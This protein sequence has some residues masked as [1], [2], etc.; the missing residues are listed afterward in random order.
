M[1]HFKTLFFTIRVVWDINKKLLLVVVLFS[2]I[3]GISPI[4]LLRFT[5]SIINAI[6]S[7]TLPLEEVIFLII[8]YGIFSICMMLIQNTNAYFAT[9]LNIVLTHKVKYE[10]MKKCAELTLE[11]LEATETYDMITRL[12]S[13]VS[14]KPYQSLTALIQIVSASITFAYAIYSI[15]VW[16]IGITILL[17]AISTLYVIGQIKVAEKDFRMRFNRSDKERKLWYY[18]FLLT[19]D[20][21]FKEIKILNLKSYFLDRY[22]KLVQT[23][24]KEENSINRIG[25]ALSIV[26]SLAQD[27]MAMVVMFVAIRE[28]YWGLILIGTTLFYINTVGIVQNTAGVLANNIHSLYN[29]NLYMELMKNFLSLGV[30]KQGDKEVKSVEKIQ[31]K[32]LGYDYPNTKNVLHNISFDISKG[33]RVAIVG[34][35]GSGKSTLLKLLCG[36]YTPASGSVLIN[37]DDLQK[38]S[39]CSYREKISVLFQDFLKFEGSLEENIHIGHI[40]IKQEKRIIKAALEFANVEFLKEAD[41]YQYS[42][43]LGSWFE[44][45][46]QLSGGQWQ[47]IALARAYYKDADVYFLDEPSSA[48]D[49]TSEMKIFKNFFKKSKGKIGVFITH[50]VRIA[51]QADKIIVI[52]RGEII[53]IGRHQ[54]LKVKC[55]FYRDMLLKE[56][57]LD[58]QVGE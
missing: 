46:S 13:E 47:K 1:K 50:R 52:D 20:T 12:E 21:A 16:N 28:A 42:R 15:L 32:G 10:L 14:V 51:K 30:K 7:M 4:V 2:V 24:I 44:G 40:D 3:G 56:K 17:V 35:N 19:R 27:I 41:E 9:Q 36:L 31:I 37:G 23:F 25:I 38:I 53:G 39:E 58:L 8:G 33:E 5:Q 43:Y 45:G 6:Q 11:R 29:S 48:L 49:V 55:P 18:S 57:E 34:A 22:W 26:I 54:D